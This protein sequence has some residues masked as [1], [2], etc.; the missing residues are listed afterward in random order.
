MRGPHRPEAAPLPPPPPS[1]PNAIDILLRQK[2]AVRVVGGAVYLDGR[3][4]TV[5]A[6]F[7]A[8]YGVP[9]GKWR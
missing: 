6:L 3:L 2:R 7:E 9:R 4:I 5:P 8:A 1:V